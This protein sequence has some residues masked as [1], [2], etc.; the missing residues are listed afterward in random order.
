M[1]CPAELLTFKV[2]YSTKPTPPCKEHDSAQLNEIIYST[3]CQ[4]LQ[5]FL[6]TEI[7]YW[8]CILPP[9]SLQ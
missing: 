5:I 9:I 1:L 7:N 8:V 6:T 3:H 2:T 4:L